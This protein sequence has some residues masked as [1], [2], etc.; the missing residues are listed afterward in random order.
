MSKDKIINFKI[1]EPVKEEFEL[2]CKDK[3]T[4]P[5]HELRLF[6]HQYIKMNQSKKLD[7][8]ELPKPSIR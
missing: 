4:T 1:E 3:F 5:S 6:V 2:M 8:S 7:L